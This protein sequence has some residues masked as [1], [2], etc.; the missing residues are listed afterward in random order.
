MITRQASHLLQVTQNIDP[1]VEDAFALGGVK[2]VDEFG[3]V[4]L[5]TLLIPAENNN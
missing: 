3:G 2:I 4:V 1:A 5:V